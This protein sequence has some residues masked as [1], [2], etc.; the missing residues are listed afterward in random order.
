M[1]GIF[2]SPAGT[3]A[4]RFGIWPGHSVGACM[5]RYVEVDP[6]DAQQGTGDVVPAAGGSEAP[7]DEAQ[8]RGHS[9]S[10]SSDSFEDISK[11]VCLF[12]YGI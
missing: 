12:P 2:R 10:G 1:I 7:T 3:E 5:Y 4:C 6:D 9:P 11:E 8:P